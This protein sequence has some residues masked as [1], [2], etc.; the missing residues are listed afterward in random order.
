MTY[1]NAPACGFDCHGCTKADFI[2]YYEDANT[3]RPVKWVFYTGN[4]HLVAANSAICLK[5]C[6]NFSSVSI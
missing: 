3:R 2:T 1:N 4:P 6:S 5:L